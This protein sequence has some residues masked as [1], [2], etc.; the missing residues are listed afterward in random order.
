MNWTLKRKPAAATVHAV[1]AAM[2]LLRSA[3]RCLVVTVDEGG[4]RDGPTAADFA[5]YLKSVG[6]PAEPIELEPGERSPQDALEELY[7]KESI[8]MLV[9]GAYTQSRLKQFIFGG[10]TKHFLTSRSCNVLMTA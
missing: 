1:T 9:M 3:S 8:D 5:G 7:R 10:F 4:R 2:P 6:V